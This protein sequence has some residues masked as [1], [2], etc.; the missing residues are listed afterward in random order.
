MINI[1]DSEEPTEAEWLA[2][3]EAYY[4]AEGAIAHASSSW[5]KEWVGEVAHVG[6][7]VGKWLI[8]HENFNT[9][10]ELHQSKKN[11]HFYME[12]STPE[13]VMDETI[14]C[15]KKGIELVDEIKD[16]V[17]PPYSDFAVPLG[18]VIGC[19]AGMNGG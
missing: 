6:T 19:I 10:N 1:G 7:D 2:A 17:P 11:W 3:E 13:G 4:R 18:Q 16:Q 5:F 15:A 8:K 12:M 14:N 9:D